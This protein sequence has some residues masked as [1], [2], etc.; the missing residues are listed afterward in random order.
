MIADGLGL[1]HVVV[2]SDFRFGKG[3]A[4]NTADL[5]AFGAQMGFDVTVAQLV[6][7]DGA[8]VSSTVDPPGS[9]RRPAARC[10]RHAGP[11]APH[12]RRRAARR[13]AR[14]RSGLSHGQHVDC[15]PAPA[16][17]GVY[18]VKVDVLTGPHQGTYDGAAS[19]GVRPM[20]G[21]NQA[22]LETFLLRFQW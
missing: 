12:R 9:D 14:A 17:F 22:N 13:K 15:R 5:E 21:E 19:L 4:G 1:S 7:T 11:L 6:E 18:A 10:G 2:G 20:F 3:R 16:T 8:E